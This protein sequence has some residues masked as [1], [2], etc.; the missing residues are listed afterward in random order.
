MYEYEIPDMS[1]GHCVATVTKAIQQADPA[2][3][4]NVDLIKRT[5]TVT[6]TVDPN[7]IGAALEEAGYPATFKA[8]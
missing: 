1:C 7:T 3:I 5:A 6:S 8:A 4:A 2:A